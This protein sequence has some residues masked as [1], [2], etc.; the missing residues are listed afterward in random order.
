MSKSTVI[1]KMTIKIYNLYSRMF[2]TTK[3]VRHFTNVPIEKLTYYP[4]LHQMFM[5]V[6]CKDEVT[7]TT[8][9]A[10]VPESLFKV[11]MAHGSVGR[12]IAFFTDSNNVVGHIFFGEE[13]H[14]TIRLEIDKGIRPAQWANPNHKDFSVWK[15]KQREIRQLDAGDDTWGYAR[16]LVGVPPYLGF[17]EDR[18]A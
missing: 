12:R 8:F 5:T 18:D 16:C 7:S 15:N 4:D 2:Q 9:T 17:K 14:N 6:G 3:Y 11:L 13:A 10:E 1:E